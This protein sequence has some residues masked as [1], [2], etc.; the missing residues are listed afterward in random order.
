MTVVYYVTATLFRG[1]RRQPRYL[2]R[3]G[4]A[5]A[6]AELR[7]PIT[8]AA[9][10]KA[11]TVFARSNP[12]IIGS[13]PTGGMDVCV[14]V[15][16]VCVVLCEGSGLATGWSPVHR[17][18]PTVCRL[19]NWKSGQGPTKGSRAI[20]RITFSSPNEGRRV[21]GLNFGEFEIAL[22]VSFF[23]SLCFSSYFLREIYKTVKYDPCAK[24]TIWY[25]EC[26]YPRSNKATQLLRDS[27]LLRN[28]KGLLPCSQKHTNGLYI[29]PVQC[30]S[31]FHNLFI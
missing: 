17:V 23:L 2:L 28:Q 24:I 30:S 21:E 27:L 18:L 9:R 1:W 22:F 16:S 25:S 4:L 13:N 26:D 5:F 3:L 19:R 15:Y 12:G 29:E 6:T 8:V 10:S 7:L 11:W 20:E 31:P 14:C